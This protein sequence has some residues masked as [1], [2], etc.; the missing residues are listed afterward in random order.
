MIKG[1]TIEVEG[2]DAYKKALADLG[3]SIG[4]VVKKDLIT[5]ALEINTD[6]KKR[7]Q[8]PPKT[9]RVYKRGKGKNL[10]R[11]HQASAPGQAPATDT[12][13]LVSSIYFQQDSDT[14]V[15]VGS[16]LAYAYYLEF[17]TRRMAPRPSWTPATE[18][19]APKL[20]AMVV[21]SIKKVIG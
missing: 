9:G 5:V 15:T 14:S 8:G 11:A 17:G 10:S 21:A 18:K 2:V 12:G 16:R 20:N 6:V 13:T 19:F 1:I 4:D 3:V 7:I